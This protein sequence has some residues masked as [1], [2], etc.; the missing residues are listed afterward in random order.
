MGKLYMVVLFMNIFSSL[1]LLPEVIRSEK[2]R[3]A[4]KIIFFKNNKP[5]F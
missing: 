3:T 1:T 4:I 5:L 2:K